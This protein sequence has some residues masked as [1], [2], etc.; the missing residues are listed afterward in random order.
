MFQGCLEFQ[1]HHEIPRDI[2][3][4]GLLSSCADF[5]VVVSANMIAVALVHGLPTN[6][7]NHL[8]WSIMGLKLMYG[9]FG[10]LNHLMAHHTSMRD[11]PA[12]V[13][14]LQHYTVMLDNKKHN[15]HHRT[16]DENFCLLGHM[17]WA[18][19][20]IDMFIDTIIPPPQSTS[21]S[22]SSSSSSLLLS[23][24]CK[25]YVWFAIWMA[26]SIF[27]LPNI[28]ISIIR[29]VTNYLVADVLFLSKV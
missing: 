7:D 6:S 16:Y 14:L 22:S 10:Q 23:S 17:D 11:R 24:G 3:N 18:V 26:I 13:R 2:V 9:Y 27:C 1:W 28:I 8:L 25:N 21:S 5:N 19:H 15:G 20:W 29:L 4:K 12:F